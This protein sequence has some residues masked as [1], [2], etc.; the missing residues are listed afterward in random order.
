MSE[1]NCTCVC[2]NCH[3][4][5]RRS[6]REIETGLRSPLDVTR[7]ASHAVQRLMDSL[8][9]N[10]VYLCNLLVIYLFF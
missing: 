1:A 7:W 3:I 6:P 9:L 4:Q 8:R 5:R 10:L 2:R